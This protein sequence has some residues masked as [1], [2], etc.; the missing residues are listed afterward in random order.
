[1]T[2]TKKKKKAPVGT[3]A[4]PFGPGDQV[5]VRTVTHHHTGRITDVG[6]DWIELE[7][8]AWIASD[9]RFHVAL[10]DGVFE[11]VEPVPGR[12]VIGRGAIID[13]YDWPHKL[14]REAK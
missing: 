8:A 1:M 7:D 3:R 2:T 14:P 5:F 12:C 10:R 13:M 11:E 4:F 9:G 6:S